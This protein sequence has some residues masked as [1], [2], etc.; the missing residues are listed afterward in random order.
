MKLTLSH[1]D[2]VQGIVAFLETR[3]IKGF[4]PLKVHASFSVSRKDQ[5]LSAVLDEDAPVEVVGDE[6]KS[7]VEAG[8]P[9]A[10]AQASATKNGENGAAKAAAVEPSASTQAVATDA[11]DAQAQAPATPVDAV[12]PEVKAAEPVAT[13]AADSAVADENLFG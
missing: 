8:K 11:S 12:E 7:P 4:D 2:I 9:E 3:G 6:P 10:A 5:S 1:N 13:E